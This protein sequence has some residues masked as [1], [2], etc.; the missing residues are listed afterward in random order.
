MIAPPRNN[1]LWA[2]LTS[3]FVPIHAPN[4]AFVLAAA[5]RASALAGR[6]PQVRHTDWGPRA[7]TLR[8][9]HLQKG[10]RL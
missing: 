8:P 6:G 9:N 3:H 2:I 4:D 10:G 5:R 1:P 7:G